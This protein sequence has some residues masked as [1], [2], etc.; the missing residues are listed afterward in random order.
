MSPTNTIV[1][2]GNGSFGSTSNGHD[3]APNKTLRHMLSRFIPIVMNT[4][5]NTSKLSCCHHMKATKL[6]TSGYTRRGAVLKCKGCSTILGRDENAAHNILHIFRHQYEHN[7]EVPVEFRSGRNG[8][9]S[10][11]TNK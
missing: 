3:S 4:E 10:C 5:Y 11:T 1:A 9:L 8:D 2:W 6:S 7:G